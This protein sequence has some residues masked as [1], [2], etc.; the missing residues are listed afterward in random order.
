VRRWSTLANSTFNLLQQIAYMGIII[1]GA[2][3]VSEHQLTMGGLIACTIIGGRVNG[4]LVA[5]LPG[6]VVQW[7]YAKSSL[8][9]LDSLLQLPMDRPA[10]QT[11]LRLAEVRSGIKLANVAFEYPGSRAG[12]DI[13]GLFIAKGEKVGVIG[14]IGS[15]KSTMLKLLAGLYAPQRGHITIDGLEIAQVA[16]NDLRQRITYLPQDYHLLSGTLRDN[17]GMGIVNP[18][19]DKLLRAVGRTGLDALVRQH[20]MGLDLPIAEGGLG[21]SGG[22]RALVGLT[23]A[24]LAES[25]VLLLDEATANLDQESEA[26][27]LRQLFATHAAASIVMI[28]HKPQLLELV[29]RLIVVLG[30]RIVLD[31]KTDQ[32]L[33][34]LRRQTQHPAGPPVD[35]VADQRA[36]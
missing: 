35:T 10:G 22:Q 3:E 33:S 12:L 4:P 11:T 19:D 21:L 8:N 2:F 14:T 24:L 6:F 15:G 25:D 9:A 28:T 26:G 36:D 31:G 18:S 32:V 27:V 7:G 34:Q 5:A 13:P 1:V 16:E 17:L 20:P 29:D 30:G 23:R